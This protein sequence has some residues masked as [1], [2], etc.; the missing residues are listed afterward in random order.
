[1][2][3]EFLVN[4][5]KIRIFPSKSWTNV[6]NVLNGATIEASIDD[7]SYDTI[8]T[9]THG[10]HVGWNSFLVPASTSAYR[11]I[12]LSHTSQSSCKII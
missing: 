8:A 9:L 2:G 5:N 3:A 7:L 4:L 12:R 11:Y 10:V 1:M 6:G